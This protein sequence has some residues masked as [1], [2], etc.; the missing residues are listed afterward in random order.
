MSRIRYYYIYRA[1]YE[2]DTHSK[3]CQRCV[4]ISD[5]SPISHLSLFII[6]SLIIIFMNE[7]ILTRFLFCSRSSLL[8]YLRYSQN[9]TVEKVS[10]LLS[11]ILASA[12]VFHV[13]LTSLS[14]FFFFQLFILLSDIHTR[15]RLLLH[16]FLVAPADLLLLETSYIAQWI[17]R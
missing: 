17:T 8:F 16:K 2:P 13:Y 5:I 14:R 1:D 11:S 7:W 6:S 9:S 15:T 4:S 12:A 10:D 3:I